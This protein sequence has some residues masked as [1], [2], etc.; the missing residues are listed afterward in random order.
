MPTDPNTPI[1]VTVCNILVRLLAGIVPVAHRTD[2]KR[3]WLAEIW[4]RWQFLFHIGQWNR[5][6][7]LRL[8]RNCLGAIPDALWHLAAQDAV[9]GRV[10]TCARSPFACLGALA[11]L[12]LMVAFA[13]SGFPATRQLLASASDDRDLLFIWLHPGIG[14]TDRGLPPDVAPA[15]ASRTHLLKAI[16]SFNI[17]RAKLASG[18][19]ADQSPLVITTEPGLFTLLDA[20]AASGTLPQTRAV[21]LGYPAWVSRFRSDPKVIGTQVRVGG[22]SYPVAAVLPPSFH[23]LTRQ[24]SLY[25]VQPRM[26]DARVMILARANPGVSTHDIDKELTRIGQNVCYY[27]FS[28]QLR[29]SLLK[30]AALA[31]LGFF[32]IAVLVSAFLSFMMCRVRATHIRSAFSR[33]N[34]Q[35]AARRALFFLGKLALTLLV[36]FTAGLEATRSESAILFA[37]KDPANGPVLVWFYII[38]T[39]A[40]FFWAVADQRSRCHVCLRLLCFPVRMGCPGCLLLD[41][42]GTELLCTEGHG[43][44]HVPHL[45]PSWEEA[46]HWIS[47]DDSW[48]SLFAGT[49]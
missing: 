14:G 31:P 40:A 41:W 44:L 28:S 1:S 16:A 47:L 6:E 20:H 38:G 23:F 18:G 22:A 13:S 32:A 34:R 30:S 5:R 2:W 29:L 19:R 37:S 43:V 12:L 35:V 49:K 42:S 27:F 15:W 7:A 48:R 8:L 46:E 26:L 4:H 21:V 17:S 25:V 10:R 39:M 45:A 24:P 9:Q 36:V 3:E 11:A 33:A